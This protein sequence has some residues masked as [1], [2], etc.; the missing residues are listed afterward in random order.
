MYPSSP[1]RRHPAS[2]RAP[3]APAP[4]TIEALRQRAA[5]V[6]EAKKRQAAMMTMSERASGS[7]DG[8]SGVLSSAPLTAAACSPDGSHLHAPPPYYHDPY[9]PVTP[10]TSSSTGI[11]T[12]PTTNTTTSTTTGATTSTAAAANLLHFGRYEAEEDVDNSAD[13]REFARGNR[14]RRL[15]A[16]RTCVGMDTSNLRHQR[17]ANPP[18][19]PV[20]PH[21][22]AGAACLQEL[23]QGPAVPTAQTT[24]ATSPT[25]AGRT[26]DCTPQYQQQMIQM[27][28]MMSEGKDGREHTRV[29]MEGRRE[30]MAAAA[31]VAD[32]KGVVSGSPFTTTVTMTM[33][34]APPPPASP[35]PQA[36]RQSSST[37]NT[38]P[39]T[40]KRYEGSCNATGNAATA[41]SSDPLQQQPSTPPPLL[42]QLPYE[43]WLRY[44]SDG[45]CMSNTTASS[46][47]VLPSLPPPFLPA[48]HVGEEAVLAEWLLLFRQGKVKVNDTIPPDDHWL[49]RSAPQRWGSAGGGVGSSS[50]VSSGMQSQVLVDSDEP[51]S[52][53][54][55]FFSHLQHG[56][57]HSKAPWNI[58]ADANDNAEHPLYLIWAEEKDVRHEYSGASSMAAATT[59][60]AAA[61]AAAAAATA[62]GATSAVHHHSRPGEDDAGN[63]EA[64]QVRLFGDAAVLRYRP[65]PRYRTVLQGVAVGTV[66]EEL[67]RAAHKD[68]L[69]TRCERYRGGGTVE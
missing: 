33:N 21:A 37:D 14:N 20:L 11:L 38:T 19:Q 30:S 69:L 59:A 27:L 23:P 65:L 36:G 57:L 31:T 13:R 67:A 7:F 56:R 46:M 44:G 53:T 42:Q 24:D 26:A 51:E 43:A 29:R 47:A 66:E 1:N 63:E 22:G 40:A 41:S 8:G 25:A 35:V 4:P 45:G 9:A 55:T 2:R 15:N 32:G 64:Y 49:P 17:P 62:G 10:A 18:P 6:E 16:R 12:M 48:T 58:C 5:E 61:A 68:R 50:S 28:R 54:G 60:M 34:A 3:P 39:R 52:L